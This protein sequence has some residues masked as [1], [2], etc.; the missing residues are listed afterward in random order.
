MI[1]TGV[2]AETMEGV[3]ATHVGIGGAVDEPGDAGIDQ[4]T[5]THGAGFEG[6]GDGAINEAP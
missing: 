6:D 2:V 1:E 5:G 3:H 4:G